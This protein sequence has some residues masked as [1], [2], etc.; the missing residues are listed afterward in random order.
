M[1]QPICPF[2]THG[3]VEGVDPGGAE[4]EDGESGDDVKGE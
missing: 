1:I 3:K 4:D 2:V